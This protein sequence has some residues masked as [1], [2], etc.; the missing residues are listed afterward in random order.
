MLAQFL[1]TYM[2]MAGTSYNQ[3]I[4]YRCVCPLQL[5]PPNSSNVKKLVR[6]NA[7]DKYFLTIFFLNMYSLFF[8]LSKQYHSNPHQVLHFLY[9]K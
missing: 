2:G 1:Q 4:Y 7:E 9:H 6:K 5:L 3:G 8:S